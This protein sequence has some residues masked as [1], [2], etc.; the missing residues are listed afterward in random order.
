MQNLFIVPQNVK[1]AVNSVNGDGYFIVINAVTGRPQ[2]F[3]QIS[4]PDI[5]QKYGYGTFMD[6]DMDPEAAAPAQVFDRETA[7]FLIACTAINYSTH[8][9]WTD[10]TT[11]G[12]PY[13]EMPIF[14]L[15]PV[16]GSVLPRS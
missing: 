4:D 15:L 12:E 9:Q 13:K 1:E 6:A 8:P 14:R 16:A 3:D 10:V 2:Y 5:A 11:C 7:M